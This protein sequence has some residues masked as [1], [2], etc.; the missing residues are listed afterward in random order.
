MASAVSANN[1][2]V[3]GGL[4]GGGGF[5]WTPMRDV[6]FNG[7]IVSEDVSGDGRT[8]VG[9]AQDHN[10]ISQAGIWLTRAEWQLLGSFSPTATPCTGSLSGAY[11]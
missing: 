3:V 7:G 9:I 5:Y 6:I 1:L 2:V 10:G 4:D 11:T 8:I